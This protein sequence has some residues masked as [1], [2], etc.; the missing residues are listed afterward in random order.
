MA[1]NTGDL[2]S[3]DSFVAA[4]DGLRFVGLREALERAVSVWDEKVYGGPIDYCCETNDAYLF[5]RRDYLSIGGPG[6]ILVWKCGG[7]F[8]NYV[9]YSLDGGYEIVREGFLSEFEK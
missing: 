9:A 3:R 7:D 2:R 5:S 8:G 1:K 6:P 4:R